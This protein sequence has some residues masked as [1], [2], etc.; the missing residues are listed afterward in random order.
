MRPAPAQVDVR[1]LELAFG[2]RRVFD[3]ISCR[4]PEGKVSTVV[5]QSGSGK[6][7]LLRCIA[8]LQPPDAGGIWV[9]DLEVTRLPEHEQRRFRRRIGMLFQQGALLDSMTVFDNVALPLREHT[10]LAEPEIADLVLGQFEAVALDDVS[11][12]LPGQLSGGMKK[13]AALARAMI[14]EPEILLAD[15]P[16]SGLDPLAIRT[17]EELLLDLNRRTGVTMILT[18]H[19][20]GSTMRMS[21]QVSFLNDGRAITGPT[22]EIQRGEHKRIREFLRAAESGPLL[23]GERPSEDAP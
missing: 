1:R 19:D 13:R 20:M 18:N 16:F 22:A 14:L 6:S 17:I 10:K 15:E 2:E 3:G 21:D 12:L 9:G 11:A 23:V 8:C 5:G 4:F 7:S